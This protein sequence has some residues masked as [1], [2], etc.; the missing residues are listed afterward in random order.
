MGEGKGSGDTVHSPMHSR[1]TI[2][3]PKGGEAVG[4]E[5][6]G[7]KKTS[8]T[9]HKT[10]QEKTQQ[11]R[12]EGRRGEEPQQTQRQRQRQRQQ[13]GEYG[14]PPCLLPLPR[15]R[16]AVRFQKGGERKQKR[17]ERRTQCESP[18]AEVATADTEQ[19]GERGDSTNAWP[20]RRHVTRVQ[21]TDGRPLWIAEK[22]FSQPLS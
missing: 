9:A 3:K 14:W 12:R 1:M 15:S 8:S 19:Q 22:G 2:M 5:Q 10:Q 11:K 21:R 6:P 20:R 7:F 17:K 18:R 13:C 16:K 4:K